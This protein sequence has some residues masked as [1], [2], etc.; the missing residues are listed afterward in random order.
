MA[1][2]LI[3]DDNQEILAVNSAYLSA[4]GFGVTTVETGMKAIV[5]LN[6]GQ[7]DCIVL[8]IMLPDID[9]LALCKAIRTMT[10]TPIIFLTCKDDPEDKIKGLMIGGDDYMTKPYSLQE[11]TARIHVLLRRGRLDA[12]NI[13]LDK[14]TIDRESRMV[15]TPEKNVFLSQKEFELFLLLFE[16]PDK[17]FSKEE[18]FE[19][20]WPNSTDMGTVAV[21]ILK[22]RRKLDFAKEYLGTIDNHYKAGYYFA[23]PPGRGAA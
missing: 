10:D 14:V 16:N 3:V 12:Q 21:H 8:D 13:S 1:N 6:A 20:L 7:Y 23:P 9:G 22:L 2:V 4:E 11:L 5:C 15:H 17:V 19:A 18:L